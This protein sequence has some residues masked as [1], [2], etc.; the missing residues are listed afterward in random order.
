MSVTKQ[1][2]FKSA[3]VVQRRCYY[4][5]RLRLSNLLVYLEDIIWGSK[6][7]TKLEIQILPSLFSDHIAKR[8][9]K[10]QDVRSFFLC[11]FFS[12]CLHMKEKKIETLWIK[13]RR[14]QDHLI[15]TCC[16]SMGKKRNYYYLVFQRQF[17]VREASR[18]SLMKKD[19]QGSN[20]LKAMVTSTITTVRGHGH[21]CKSLYFAELVGLNPRMSPRE[22]G[23]LIVIKCFREQALQ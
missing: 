13:K 8:V 17:C 9:R 18:M 16:T 7:K 4:Y 3:S 21:R 19:T 15:S 23:D 1:L 6:K 10:S 22:P 2:I 11:L 20:D 14:R 5:I 12:W